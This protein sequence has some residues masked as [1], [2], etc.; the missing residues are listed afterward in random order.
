[1][2]LAVATCANNSS[3]DAADAPFIQACAATGIEAVRSVWNDP[4]V[5]WS[6]H[7]ACLIRTT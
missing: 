4:L 7:D 6:S 2:K 1:M 3:A 5:D